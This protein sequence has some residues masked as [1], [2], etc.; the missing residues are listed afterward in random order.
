[1]ENCASEDH[2]ETLYYDASDSASLK[3]A[4][5]AIGEDLSEIHLSK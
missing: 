3:E 1:M 4:F 2:G 5:R